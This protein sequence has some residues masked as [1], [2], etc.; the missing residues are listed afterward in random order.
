VA[1]IAPGYEEKR[2][3]AASK[4]GRLRLVASPDGRDGSVTIHQDAFAHATLLDGTERVVHR[5]AD[6]RKVYVHVARS[7]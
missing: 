3:D 4:R 6:G 1:G 5:P 7:A 2:F